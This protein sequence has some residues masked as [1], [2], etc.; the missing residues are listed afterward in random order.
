[1]KIPEVSGTEMAFGIRDTSLLT[2][3]DSIPDEFKK[4]SNKWHRVVS[5]WFFDGCN[6]EA[7]KFKDGVDVSRALRFTKACLT[8]WAFKHEH[9]EAGVAYFLSQVCDDV[10]LDI[11]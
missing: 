7:F 11:L 10:D 3:Y 1:M 4:H 9:K 5:K 2:P 6:S 8:S